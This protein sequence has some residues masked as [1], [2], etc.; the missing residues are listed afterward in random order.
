MNS[1]R[2]RVPAT[3]ANLGPGFDALGLAL[4]LWNET[5]FTLPE[6]DQSGIRLEISG[7][8]AGALPTDSSNLIVR[9]AQFLYERCGQP[10]PPDLCIRCTNR[11]PLG[12]GL[13][14]SA[15]AVVSGLL[16]ANGL[17]GRPCSPLEVLAMATEIEGHPDNAGAAVLGGLEVVVMENGQVVARKIEIS[18][19]AVAVAVP[20]FNLPTH[21]A[22]AA[23]P[24]QVSLADAVFNLGRTALVIESLRTGDLDLLGWVM[25][26]RL[27]QPYRLPLIPGAEAAMLAALQAGAS[28]A[29]LSGAGPGVV[30]FGRVDMA[31][32]AAAMQAAFQSAGL[33][34]RTWILST[35]AHGAS[36]V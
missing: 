5:E 4:D 7:E 9:S 32:A 25:A 3:T 13:G 28:A 35:T 10:F 17:L 11:I 16:G 15:A 29:A 24:R 33:P 30:A 20:E 21:A 34:A 14:S 26:D 27:H 22:R 12:S 2:V 1:L 8:G 6:P 18:A 19:L 31:P 23:L 36:I